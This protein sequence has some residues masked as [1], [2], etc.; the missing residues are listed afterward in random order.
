[1]MKEN[2][3]GRG[4]ER[5]TSKKYDK[6]VSARIGDCLDIRWKEDESKPAFFFSAWVTER[7]CH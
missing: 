6:V 1:M 5:H 3:I 7:G 2:G 4:R